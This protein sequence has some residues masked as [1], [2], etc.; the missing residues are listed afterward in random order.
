MHS[1]TM[2]TRVCAAF[3]I[4]L[5]NIS[6][7]LASPVQP[8]SSE[9]VLAKRTTPNFP[10]DIPSCG[11]CAGN[12]SSISSCAAAVPVLQNFTMVRGRSVHIVATSTEIEYPR[13]YSIPAPS[14]ML[15]SARARIPS[16][17]HI[18]NVSIGMLVFPT[19]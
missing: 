15:S 1:L 10:S 18:L 5:L 8:S 17:P 3:L 13:F 19:E 11:I 4:L 16:K 12:Y 9:G 6:L 7:V 2:L 14:L